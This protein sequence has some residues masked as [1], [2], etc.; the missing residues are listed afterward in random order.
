MGIHKTLR[1]A[2]YHMKIHISTKQF[3]HTI[4]EGVITVPMYSGI[5]VRDPK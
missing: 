4:F 2:Y 1:V 5:N 3:D